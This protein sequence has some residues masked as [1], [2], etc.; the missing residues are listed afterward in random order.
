MSLGRRANFFAPKSLAKWI[1]LNLVHRWISQ[2]VIRFHSVVVV[3]RVVVRLLVV[4]CLLHYNYN[5]H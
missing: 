3:D 1:R 5:K 2:I 4:A